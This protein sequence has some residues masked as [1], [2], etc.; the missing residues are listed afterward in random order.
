MA[1][2][3]WRI[4]NSLLV[5]RLNALLMQGWN[6]KGGPPLT[7]LACRAVSKWNRIVFIDGHGEVDFS[8]PGNDRPVVGSVPQEPWPVR[9]KSVGAEGYA[10]SCFPSTRCGLPEVRCDDTRRPG[11][12]VDDHRAQQ[13]L[14]VL[15]RPVARRARSEPSHQM[16]RCQKFPRGAG[17]VLGDSS[18]CDQK[19]ASLG[20]EDARHDRVVLGCASLR[21][22]V[23]QRV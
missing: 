15:L 5:P 21:C 1:L 3:S 7:A 23:R 4:G 9:A 10:A 12:I 13:H 22:E 11:R 14:Q 6:G 20:V 17:A 19:L 2:K 16:R 18:R 8:N